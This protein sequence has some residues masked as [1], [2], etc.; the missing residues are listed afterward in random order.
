MADVTESLEA[1]KKA[2]GEL[3]EKMGVQDR[4]VIR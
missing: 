4:E 1:R 3:D 2:K